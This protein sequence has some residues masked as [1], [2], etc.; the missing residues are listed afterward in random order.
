MGER[1]NCC[2]TC[3]N[4]HKI[5]GTTFG[6]INKQLS[7]C[8]EA[9]ILPDFTNANFQHD[10]SDGLRMI[11]LGLGCPQGILD[12]ELISSGQIPIEVWIAFFE[13][14]PSFDM[15]SIGRTSEL[16]ERVSSL[17]KRQR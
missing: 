6:L 12:E 4:R 11:G 10:V 5:N 1:I 13:E 15:S 14:N 7:P 17:L 3:R 9:F 8:Y 2:E 16:I